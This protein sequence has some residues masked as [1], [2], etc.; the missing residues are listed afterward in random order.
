MQL[1]VIVEWCTHLGQVV[2]LKSPP[3]DAQNVN[4]CPEVGCCY[5]G[6]KWFRQVYNEAAID[7]IAPQPAQW[8]CVLLC[9]RYRYH[10]ANLGT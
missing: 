7:E 10:L 6:P 2:K 3:Q 4:E 5:R 8:G 9:P 1:Q